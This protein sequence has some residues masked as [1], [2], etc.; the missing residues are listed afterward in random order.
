MR[1]KGLKRLISSVMCAAMVVTG[2]V[3]TNAVNVTNTEAAEVNNLE[4]ASVSSYVVGKDTLP[5]TE[6]E[7]YN[8]L[9]DINNI[10]GINIDISNS[11]IKKLQSDF[12]KNEKSPIYRMADVKI[13]ITIPSKGT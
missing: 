1:K 12:E 3:S 4:T 2:T 7:I 9:F 8:Q 6:K 13:T 11:E 5:F 10:V